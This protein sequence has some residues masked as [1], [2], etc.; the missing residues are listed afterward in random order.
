MAVG[1]AAAIPRV[2]ALRW[3]WGPCCCCTLDR[4]I[5]GSPGWWG[6]GRAIH[7]PLLE[8]A[9]SVWVCLCVV[10]CRQP[11]LNPECLHRNSE[12]S[13]LC[14][15]CLQASMTT[16]LYGGGRCHPNRHPRNSHHGTG[17]TWRSTR[18]D[19]GRPDPRCLLRRAWRAAAHRW[20]GSC[21]VLSA[22]DDSPRRRRRRAGHTSCPTAA[23]L[24]SG[25]VHWIGLGPS[26]RPRNSLTPV[27]QINSHG[28]RRAP[29]CGEGEGCR[30]RR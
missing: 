1:G 28:R 3:R 7:Q 13:H 11:S 2:R 25:W 18:I 27:P 21:V 5:D 14:L 20:P 15:A 12:D 6:H 22:S 23:A 29:A 10:W 4:R 26:L 19:R 16:A 9:L 17:R 30:R 24:D 8:A